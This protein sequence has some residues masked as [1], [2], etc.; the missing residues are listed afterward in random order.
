MGIRLFLAFELPP[1]IREQI[2]TV[3]RE[4]KKSTLPVRW[5]KVENI[6]LTIVFIGSVNED[7]IDDIKEK[8]H[9]VVKSSFVFKTRL[10]GVGVFPNLRR[11][12]V[13]WVGLNGETERL[14]RFRDE[15]QAELKVLGIRE[16]RRPF[17]PHLTIG[18][19]KGIVDR[20]EELKWILD[21]YHDIRTDLH[22]LNELI[23]FKSDLKPDGPIYTKMAVWPLRAADSHR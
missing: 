6:H 14:S 1:T 10:N 4:L 17:R 16:E 21:K 20:D 13:I 19:F 2:G 18:R 8:V 15:L 3:S 7:T 9:G 11:P 23:L 5:V 22:Y 12:R